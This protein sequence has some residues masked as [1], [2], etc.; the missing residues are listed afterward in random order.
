MLNQPA[1]AEIG[2]KVGDEILLRIGAASQIPADSALGRKSETVRNRRLK[3][4]AIIPA[5]G[6]GRFA[7]NP[8]Q[9]VPRV[10]YV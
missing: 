4:S 7:L 9:L 8:S 1:A 10:A 3:I 5:E 6:L 2:A